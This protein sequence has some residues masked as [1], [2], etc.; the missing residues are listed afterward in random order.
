MNVL[1][2]WLLGQWLHATADAYTILGGIDEKQGNG[3]NEDESIITETLVH[4]NKRLQLRT[5]SHE[6]SGRVSMAGTLW[7]AAPVLAHYITNPECPVEGFKRMVATTNNELKH[8]ST[9]VELGSG[10]GLVSIA[11]ALLGCHVVATD[12]SPSSIRLL[13]EN[14][15]RYNNEFSVRP[16]ISLLGWGDVGAADKLIKHE[17][18][19][20]YPDVIVASDVVYAHS[21]KSELADTIKY[22]CPSGHTG[23]VLIAHRWRTEP[24]EE[25]KFFESFDSEFDREELGLEWFPEDSYYRTKS[26]IDFKYPISIYTLRRKC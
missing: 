2:F 13:E 19:G 10:V 6:R 4:L 1:I 24:V 17:L 5:Q 7:E 23:T 9:V 12:G 26:M 3:E 20:Q 14:F 18:L 22:L 8:P 21:A 15:E 16:R 11:S 25:L